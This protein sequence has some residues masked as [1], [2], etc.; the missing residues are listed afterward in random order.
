MDPGVLQIG[1]V[2]IRGSISVLRFCF[3][4]QPWVTRLSSSFGLGFTASPDTPAFFCFS[5]KRLANETGFHA[6]LALFSSSPFVTRPLGTSAE[7]LT[8]RSS[9]G[10]L[11]LPL[12]GLPASQQ[13]TCKRPSCSLSLISLR[14]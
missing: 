3:F 6:N 8:P 1:T 4:S 2:R 11:R 7:Q 5:K 14:Q 10:R 12:F 13:G 9:V